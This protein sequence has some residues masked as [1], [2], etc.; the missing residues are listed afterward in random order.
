MIVE[1]AGGKLYKASGEKFYL[2]DHLNGA[3]IDE[4]LL[5]TSA[6]N[7]KSILECLEKRR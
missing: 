7:C 1:A 6:G 5:V 3:R 4:H 2:N